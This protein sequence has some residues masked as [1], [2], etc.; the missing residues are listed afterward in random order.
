MRMV[1]PDV[2][3]KTNT[4]RNARGIRMPRKRLIFE[5]GP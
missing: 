1:R 3:A 2:M 5:Y 4:G